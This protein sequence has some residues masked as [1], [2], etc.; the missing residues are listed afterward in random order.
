MAPASS[1]E[2]MEDSQPRPSDAMGDVPAVQH[3]ITLRYRA[4][5][6]N[7]PA[8]FEL[9]DAF[10]DANL[11][12]RDP[13]EVWG[14]VRVLLGSTPPIELFDELIVLVMMDF[15]QVQVFKFL[16]SSFWE[17]YLK[18][19][20]WVSS[21]KVLK[22]SDF[23]W[24]GRLG[25]GG[26]GSVYACR[27]QDTGRLYAVKC[28]SKRKVKHRRATKLVLAERQ[29]LAG[30]DTP[31]VTGLQYAFQDV[32]NI[33]YVLDIKAGGDLEQHLL[34]YGSFREE[35]VRQYMAEILLGLRYLHEHG[36][37][38]R[39]LKPANILL[40]SQGHA[41]LS[42]LGLATFVSNPHLNNML[43]PVHR[44]RMITLNGKTIRPY[45]RGKAGTPGFWAPEMLLRDDDNRPSKYDGAADWWSF[46][47]LAYALLAGRGPFTVRHGTTDD[48][49]RAT[50]TAE[51]QY[52]RRIFSDAA[53]D[54]LRRLL[55]R[56]PAARLGSGPAGILE[57]MQHPFFQGV[58]WSLLAQ[59]L[60]SVRWYPP[61][62]SVRLTHGPSEREERE[63]AELASVVLT[64]EDQTLY[65]NVEYT[66]PHA[67]C[68]EI[69]ENV[70]INSL[71]DAL[72]AANVTGANAH[73]FVDSSVALLRRNS[74]AP[75]DEDEEAMDAVLAEEMAATGAGAGTGTGTGIGT[76]SQM[77][78]AAG[79]AEPGA[80]TLGTGVG[81][82]GVPIAAPG[83]V[84]PIG[85]ARVST[86]GGPSR[87]APRATV[88][89]PG[90]RAGATNAYTAHDSSVGHSMA[91]MPGTGVPGTPSMTVGDQPSAAYMT[92]AAAM[93]GIA[94]I[95][96]RAEQ[97]AIS[98][99]MVQAVVV[100]NVDIHTT[101]AARVAM[102]VMPP[103]AVEAMRQRLMQEASAGTGA[104]GTVRLLHGRDPMPTAGMPMPTSR[105]VQVQ[106]DAMDHGQ[107][108]GA[109]DAPDAAG[110]QAGAGTVGGH[111]AH[112]GRH[113]HRRN[114]RCAMM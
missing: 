38:H 7:L 110:V 74:S 67:L 80:A 58:E 27:K 92:D 95:R 65:D 36:I 76:G 111:G 88:L 100:S 86:L 83:G 12:V 32:D 24:L 41:C 96:A 59:G 47:C 33:Y 11:R 87:L 18:Y 112:H 55:V 89:P 79:I 84:A 44:G 85:A 4:Q 99:R 10:R 73:D 60:V 72:T 54:L 103:D 57:I 6:S 77:L 109:M 75:A 5:H 63:K 45:T 98:D 78:A 30:V 2:S 1:T 49:N 9:L 97:A 70:S 17:T 48:D 68:R 51:P 22:P 82:T 105:A 35:I 21:P 16:R 71:R 28:M 114:E 20:D 90:H 53:T 8:L 69:I 93:P 26:Y 107:E 91:Y 29:I 56:D 42:D 81:G 108:E 61:E 64:D 62:D 43:D 106:Q 113:G 13:S 66:W 52:P 94:T 15:E 25:R 31:F 101:A 102:D 19:S 34:R 14:S 50:L 39:D 46:G 40:D 37:M 23:A 3:Y 104:P